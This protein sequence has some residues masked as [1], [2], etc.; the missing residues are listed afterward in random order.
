MPGYQIGAVGIE[1]VGE[2]LGPSMEPQVLFPELDP[3]VFARHLDWMVPHY[4]DPASRRFITSIHSWVVRTS[5]HTILVDACGGNHK[6]R[7]HSRRF[8]MNEGP[9]LDHLR[10]AGLSPE[11]IDIVLCTHLHV[12]HVGWNTRLQDGRWV[13]TFP[14]ARYLF[15][16]AELSRLDPAL[17]GPI[18]D[19]DSL[20]YQDSV[21]PVIASGQARLI[22]G[23]DEI[24]AGLAI[25]P[26]PGHTPGHVILK[27]AS[28]GER[29][30]FS[31]DLMHHPIQVYAP[32]WNSRF[33]EDPQAA[34]ASRRRVLE[35]CAETGAL[36]LPAHFGAPHAGHVRAA[37]DGFRLEFSLPR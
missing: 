31:G 3:E 32:E 13:P 8:H 20:I 6:P 7:P 5:R 23:A 36:L 10:A 11:D 12:D 24:E 26:A 16:R 28:G 14:N 33:C 2:M 4:Y 29:A 15:A 27:V 19:E 37:G 18:E 22:E 9:Y 21:L 25:E 34:R 1:R 17:R 30:V 35:H